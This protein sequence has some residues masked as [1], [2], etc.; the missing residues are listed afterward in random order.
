[1]LSR[2]KPILGAPL[3]PAP[4]LQFGCQRAGAARAQIRKAG[5]GFLGE[6]TDPNFGVYTSAFKPRNIQLSLKVVF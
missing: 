4:K 5:V 3:L 6:Q 2:R 1:M